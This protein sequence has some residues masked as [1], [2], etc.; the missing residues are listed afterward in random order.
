MAVGKGKR[1]NCPGDSSLPAVYLF[2]CQVIRA[3]VSL[4]WPGIPSYLSSPES[5][6]ESLRALTLFPL[7]SIILSFSVCLTQGTNSSLFSKQIEQDV[8]AGLW[9]ASSVG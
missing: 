7:G 1:R 3:K 6:E 2:E 5:F 4:R 9:L 8:A